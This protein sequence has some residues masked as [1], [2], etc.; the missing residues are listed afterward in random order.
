[1]FS[2]T[3]LRRGKS[4]QPARQS[5]PPARQR[6]RRRTALLLEPLEYRVLLYLNP[7]ISYGAG[8]L[9]QSVA[10]AD[11]TGKGQIDLVTANAASDDVSVLLGLGDGSFGFP[12]NY[13]VGRGPAAV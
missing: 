4:S 8:Q 1:M 12:V 5:R 3:W 11:L 7:V 9:P 2:A 10:A 13:P 6:Q